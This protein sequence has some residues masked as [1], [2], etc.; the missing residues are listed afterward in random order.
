VGKAIRQIGRALALCSLLGVA[1]AHAS[2]IGITEIG[3]GGD[4]PAIIVTSGFGEDALAFSDRTH[5]HNGAAFDT[6]SG[7][8]SITGTTIVSLP[9]YLVGGDYIRFANNARDQSGYSATVTADTL[10]DWYLLLDNRLNGP[11]GDVSSPNTSDAV[12]GGTLQW[13]IDG[14][15]ARVNTGISPLAQA[16]YTGVDEGGNATGAGMGLN[17]FYSVWTL[18]ASSVIVSNNGIGASNMISLV[19]TPQTQVPEPTTLLLLGLGLAGL[20][21][22][23]KRPRLT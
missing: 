15:W 2:I 21:F 7:L 23:R 16:D 5:Q 9:S 20:G 19:A 22:A 12:L 1:Q 3:L 11:S 10:S 18:A 8:L 17:Q 13:V 6:S 14:G 4:A